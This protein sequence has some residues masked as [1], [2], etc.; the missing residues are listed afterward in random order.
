MPRRSASLANADRDFVKF[1]PKETDEIVYNNENNAKEE[2]NKTDS[3]EEGK[4]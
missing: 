3:D 1:I 2:I 4:P